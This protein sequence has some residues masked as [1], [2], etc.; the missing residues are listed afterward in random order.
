[1]NLASFIVLLILMIGVAFAIRS[2]IKNKKS[3]KSSC[4]GNCGACGCDSLCHSQ[5]AKG[6]FKEIRQKELS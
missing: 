4:G 5:K 2:I 3:G 6:M 1:M